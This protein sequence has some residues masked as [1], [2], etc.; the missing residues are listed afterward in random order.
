MIRYFIKAG[1]RDAD[2]MFSKYLYANNGF[3]TI[4]KDITKRRDYGDGLKLLLIKYYVDGEVSKY[5]STGKRI[6]NYSN[7]NKDISVDV[8]VNEEIFHSKDENDRKKFIIDSTLSSVKKVK[9]KLNKKRLQIDFNLL[10]DDIERAQDL[11][12][13]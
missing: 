9:E 3:D 12:L 2:T 13:L 5:Q 1:G 8:Y 4:F 10:I 7:K 11:Y 6:S